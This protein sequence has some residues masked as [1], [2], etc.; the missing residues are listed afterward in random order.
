[1]ARRALRDLGAGA[2]RAR[3]RGDD[4]ARPA[5]AR[6]AAQ[7]KTVVASERDEAERAAW[8]DEAAGLA[9]ADL[10]FVGEGS[11][12]R[13]AT[14]RRARAPRGQR[15]VG[16]APRNRGSNGTLLAAL[17]PAG[18][19]PALVVAGAA[20]G[21]AFE[22][23]PRAVL[24]PALRPGQVVVLDNLSV[25]KGARARGLVEAAGCRLLFLPPPSP[26]FGPIA[27][28]S[29]KPTQALRRAAARTYEAL[30]AA[31]G[32]APAAITVADARAFFAHCGFPLPDQHL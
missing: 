16:A 31:I 6:L 25:H 22:A 29:A 19:G 24:L 17:T 3:Q 28:A 1:H 11:A 32:A 12:G 2:R 7:K 20:D 27:L 18:V 13:G 30:V 26:D 5:P 21:P 23:Y 10:V 8:R 15:A 14:P 4:V 9:P